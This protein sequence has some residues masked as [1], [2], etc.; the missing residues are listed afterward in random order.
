VA[1]TQESAP[2]I[3]SE[4]QKQL[5]VSPADVLAA[6]CR[7]LEEFLLE[8]DPAQTYP[9]EYIYFRITGFRPSE[10]FRQN[11][12]GRELLPEL[13]RMLE[14]LSRRAPRS[15]ES[16]GEEVMTMQQAAEA[17]GVSVRTVQRWRRRGLVC[18]TYRF[19]DGEVR[20]GIR[21]S[22]MERF[23]HEH[24]ELAEN[25][26]KFNRMDLSEERE[27][28][29]RARNYADQGLGVTATARKVAAELGRATET[30]RRT[31]RDHDEDHPSEAV[32]AAENTPEAEPQQVLERYRR[33]ESAEELAEHYGLSRQSIYRLVNSARA[34]NLLQQPLQALHED[35]F[36][37]PDAAQQ[38]LDETY[39]NARRLL[40]EAPRHERKRDLVRWWESHL[41]HQQ[42]RAL[43]RGYNFRKDRALRLLEDVNPRRYVSSKLLDTVEDHLA[44]ARELRE[45]LVT[46]HLPLAD[47]VAWQHAGE[48]AAAEDLVAQGRR[49]L[50]ELVDSFDYRGKGRFASYATLELLKRFAREGDGQ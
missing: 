11:Y 15:T 1:R 27:A 17:A 45:E 20:R 21:S 47:H 2:Q 48:R 50:P 42:E 31:I 26:R 18:R 41:T 33:G 10:D 9:Y 36:D 28:V 7:R 30:V 16:T 25:A 5:R 6:H 46:A 13:T 3:L 39:R 37:E 29:E 38:I 43:F 24:P 34:E 14:D 32:F 35:A 49:E 40:A 12:E 22:A 23:M 4:L 44:R 8:F 19:P